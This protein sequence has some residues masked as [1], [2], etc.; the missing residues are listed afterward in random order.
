MMAVPYGAV[1]A[2][3]KVT[4]KKA[5]KKPK[6]RNRNMRFDELTPETAVTPRQL[7][8]VG[9]RKR[10]PR[11]TPK[12]L[13]PTLRTRRQAAVKAARTTTRGGY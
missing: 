9:A 7:A 13:Q 11:K 12:E 1:K 6:K 10:K 4:A 8:E 5:A 3:K 2:P